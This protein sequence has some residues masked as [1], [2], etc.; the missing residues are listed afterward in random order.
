MSA[1]NGRL[2]RVCSI[3]AATPMRRMS[4]RCLPQRRVR[5]P[6]ADLL[7]G[8]T[9]CSIIVGSSR[10]YAVDLFTGAPVFADF[11]GLSDMQITDRYQSLGS[12]PSGRLLPVFLEEGV[13]GLVPTGAGALSQGVGNLMPERVYWNQRQ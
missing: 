12:G 13:T 1:S 4:L 3:P 5:P 8:Q 9:L 10:L 6:G 7:L 2:C 11:N